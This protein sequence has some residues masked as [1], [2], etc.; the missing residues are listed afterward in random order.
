MVAYL[1]CGARIALLTQ[2][3][4]TLGGTGLYVP[5]GYPSPGA[6][7]TPSVSLYLPLNRTALAPRRADAYVSPRD[8][9]CIGASHRCTSAATS[10]LRT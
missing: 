8:P 1:H 6:S 10:K 4:V 5:F 2:S 7:P 3:Q 9:S